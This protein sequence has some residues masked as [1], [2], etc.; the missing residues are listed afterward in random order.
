MCLRLERAS[1]RTISPH[2]VDV[3][4]ERWECAPCCVHLFLIGYCQSESI[5]FIALARSV[6]ID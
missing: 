5:L 1:E 3:A 4:L 6:F 2:S